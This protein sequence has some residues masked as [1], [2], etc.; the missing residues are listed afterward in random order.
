MTLSRRE[1]GTLTLAGVPAAWTAL[2]LPLQAA[3]PINSKIKGVQI[4]DITGRCGPADHQGVR[5]RGLGEM[6]LMSGGATR[7]RAN[8]PAAAAR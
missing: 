3:G 2:A 1:F 8:G 4:A 5:Q 7:R 6:E